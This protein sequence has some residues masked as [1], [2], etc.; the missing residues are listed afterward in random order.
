MD[1]DLSNRRP[2]HLC[3][4]MQ[5]MFAER[6]D[7]HTPWM[8]KV[9]PVVTE[10]ARTHSAE[11]IFTRFI[12]PE[13]PEH[14]PGAWRTYFERWRSF[15]RSEIDLELLDLVEPL[16]E[17]TPPASLC[18]KPALSAFERT[19]LQDFLDRRKVD[20]L[21][22][23]GAETDVCVLATVVSAVDRGFLV[24]LPKDALCSSTDETH[25]ALIT[26]YGKRFAAQVVLTDAE[27]LLRAWPMV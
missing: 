21:V 25:D 2:A 1:L 18:D 5:R 8:A 3:V 22:I 13:R 26:L 27:Q 12:P 9:I 17:L 11:T 20:T 16:R 19:D 10:I 14:A 24:V 23:T 15:T 6:T 4:D 7:W